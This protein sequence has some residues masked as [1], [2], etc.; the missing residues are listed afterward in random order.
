MPHFYNLSNNDLETLKSSAPGQVDY[1]AADIHAI[2]HY[3]FTESQVPGR[4]G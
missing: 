3:L 4:D 1:P 2:T